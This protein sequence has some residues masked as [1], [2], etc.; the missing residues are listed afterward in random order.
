MNARKLALQLMELEPR[1]QE[2]LL[3]ELPDERRE[4]M[5]ALILEAQAAAR[6][7]VAAFEQELRAVEIEDSAGRSAAIEGASRSRADLVRL[8]DG[9]LRIL[10][11][12]EQPSVQQRVINVLRNGDIDAWPPSVR[13]VVLTWLRANQQT[14]S[15]APADRPRSVPRWMRWAIGR[16]SA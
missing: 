9:Q 6:A 8:N 12:T 14:S 11:G 15:V 5:Q 16:R 1:E 2:R 13:R 10:L 3:A 4:H 7:P